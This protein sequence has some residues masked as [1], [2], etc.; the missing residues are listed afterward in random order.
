MLEHFHQQGSVEDSL[1]KF[2]TLMRE[3]FKQS[4]RNSLRLVHRLLKTI[5][6][7]SFY[8]NEALQALLKEKVGRGAMLFTQT[9]G[10]KVAVVAT[11]ANS[12]LTAT[13]LS[14]YNG[15]G[16]CADNSSN[17]PLLIMPNPPL[18][19]RY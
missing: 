16:P 1:I 18:T 5:T 10:T 9:S 17:G 8:N 4:R 19:D 2:K 3:F 13:L 15:F 14:N 11:T 12:E 7:K 6:S